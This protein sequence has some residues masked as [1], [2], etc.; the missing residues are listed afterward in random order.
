MVSFQPGRITTN[1]IATET[2]HSD[3]E[4]LK[5]EHLVHTRQRIDVPP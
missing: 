2:I 1:Y 5:V 4:E 3:I